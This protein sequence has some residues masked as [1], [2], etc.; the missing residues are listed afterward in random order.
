MW[1][2]DPQVDGKIAIV[3]IIVTSMFDIITSQACE[4]FI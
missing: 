2:I 4:I 1:I 3:H